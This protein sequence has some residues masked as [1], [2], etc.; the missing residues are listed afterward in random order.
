MTS[1]NIPDGFQVWEPTSLFMNHITQI[2]SLYKNETGSVFGMRIDQAHANMHNVA[3]GGLLATL[4]DC[5]LGTYITQECNAPVVT[6]NMS[7]DYL[8]VTKIGDWLEA[9]VKIE[10]QGRRLIY[11]SCYLQ[12]EGKTLVKV[13]GIFAVRG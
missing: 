5:A 6:V 10:K 9:H 13:N 11:A 3:H 4:A 12:T 1:N 7:L 2:G 8:S